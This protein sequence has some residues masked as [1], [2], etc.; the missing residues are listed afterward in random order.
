[1]RQQFVQPSRSGKVQHHHG[2]G[3]FVEPPTPVPGYLGGQ[4]R[5]NSV[6]GGERRQ[7]CGQSQCV[8][9][10]T[11]QLPSLLQSDRSEIGDRPR[12]RGPDVFGKHVAGRRS[13]RERDPSKLGWVAMVSAG[14]NNGLLCS[15]PGGTGVHRYT[16]MIVGM[17]INTQGYIIY[18][19][20]NCIYIYFYNSTSNAPAQYAFPM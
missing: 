3:E 17:R 20:L 13:T 5:T 4:R 15:T 8:F 12:R 6:G 11:L 7:Q 18:I 2:R 14:D 1:M 10:H 9:F 19:Y 16:N